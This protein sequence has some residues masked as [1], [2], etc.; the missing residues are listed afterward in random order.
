MFFCT[1]VKKH[2]VI[3]FL[4]KELRGEGCKGYWCTRNARTFFFDR[5]TEG[6]IWGTHKGYWC[7]RNARN[8]QKF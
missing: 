7:T 6:H 4:A 3:I 8:T 2:A 5:R 1:S